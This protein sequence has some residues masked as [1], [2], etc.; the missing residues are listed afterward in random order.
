MTKEEAKRWKDENQMT[1]I[2]KVIRSGQI[3]EVVGD[4]L[5]IGDVNPGGTIIAGGNI[6]VMGALRGIA[7][8]GHNGNRQ[9]FI[10][11]SV[12]KP[13]HIRIADKIMKAPDKYI[14]DGHVMECAFI[15]ETGH[16]IVEKIQAIRNH[17]PNFIRLEGGL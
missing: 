5:L 11:A 8:A 9:S 13:S 3:F 17:R 15:D 16:I 2:A 4:L 12:M 7:Q 10:S 1:T 6:F 14:A